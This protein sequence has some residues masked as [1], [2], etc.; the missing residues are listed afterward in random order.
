LADLKGGASADFAMLSVAMREIRSM[1]ESDV[2]SA[3]SQPGAA[4]P[5]AK[6]AKPKAKAKSKAKAKGKAA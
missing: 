2:G 5:E 3:D 6:S 1:H 4:A